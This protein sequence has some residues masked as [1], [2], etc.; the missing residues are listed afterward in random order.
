M[1]V[2]SLQSVRDDGP[3]V[4]FGAR[5][6]SFF[7][8]RNLTSTHEPL[9]ERPRP[10]LPFL[11]PLPLCGRSCSLLCAR[12]HMLRGMSAAQVALVKQHSRAGEW[13]GL[14]TCPGLPDR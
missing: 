10:P 12:A 4:S 8:L 5:A 6:A 2:V 7:F 11:T 14:Q 3:R 13:R 1:G 9:R